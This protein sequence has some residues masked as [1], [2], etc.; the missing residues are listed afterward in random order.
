MANISR[1]T[2]TTTMII[3]INITGVGA[4]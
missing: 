2:I 1:I 3:T 4:G